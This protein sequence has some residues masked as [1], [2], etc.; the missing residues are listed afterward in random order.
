MGIGAQLDPRPGGAFR[1]DVDGEHF[2]AGSY[3]EVKA[4][5]RLVFSWG[6]EGS[7]EVAPGSTMVEITLTPDGDGTVLRLRHSDLPTEAERSNHRKG[8]QL[9]TGRL[10]G[11]LGGGETPPPPSQEL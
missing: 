1:I 11:V 6:W 5:H 7:G 3:R 9:Y 8:W 4:P 10:A 2:A